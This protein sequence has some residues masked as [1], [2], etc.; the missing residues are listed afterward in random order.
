MSWV[1]ESLA[2][3]SWSVDLAG[4]VAGLVEG[5]GGGSAE[6]VGADPGEFVGF[7]GLGGVDLGE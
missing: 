7:G 4:G 5:G 2:W 1:M 6:G 3:P